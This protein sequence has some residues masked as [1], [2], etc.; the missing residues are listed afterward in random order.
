MFKPTQLG[1]DAAHQPAPPPFPLEALFSEPLLEGKQVL[2]LLTE[3]YFSLESTGIS[4]RTYHNWRTEGLLPDCMPT[5][6]TVQLDLSGFAWLKIV[7]QLKSFGFGLE[8]IRQAKAQLFEPVAFQDLLTLFAAHPQTQQ[9]AQQIL[10]RSP[11]PDVEVDQIVALLSE[12]AT[13]EVA[14][15]SMPLFTLLVV[16]TL[17]VKQMTR[18]LVLS[19]G[20]VLPLLD[21]MQLLD[22]NVQKV[23]LLPHI[24]LSLYTLLEPL[25]TKVPSQRTQNLTQSAFL[26]SGEEYSILRTMREGNLNELCIRFDENHLPSVMLGVQGQQVNENNKALLTHLLLDSKHYEVNKKHNYNGQVYVQRTFRK[27]L[28]LKSK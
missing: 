19:S 20:Q 15:V 12:V 2:G 8:P 17:A 16:Q 26:I 13:A 1:H 10:L 21:E 9:E 22:A 5:G 27:R 24:S 28:R 23:T 7:D 18:L 4:L 3:K 25:L 6:K 11:L 14:S